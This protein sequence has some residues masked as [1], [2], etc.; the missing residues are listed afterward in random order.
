MRADA[1]KKRRESV[2]PM[3]SSL[4]EE[5][6]RARAMMVELAGLQTLQDPVFFAETEGNAPRRS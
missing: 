6:K 3:T 1:D 5:V 4:L 2:V